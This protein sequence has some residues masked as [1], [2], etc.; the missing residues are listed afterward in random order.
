MQNNISISVIIPVYQDKEGLTDTV[1]SLIAQDFDKRQYEI[2]ISDNNSKDGTKQTATALHNGNPDLIRVVH[3]DTIQ[4]SYA[5]R[6]AAVKIARGEICCFID[7]DMTADSN[8]L[9]KVFNHFRNDEH[10]MYFGCNVLILK[11]ANTLS[12]SIN[13]DSGFKMEQYF[14]K[15]HFTPTASLSVRKSIFDT[16]GFF[17]E[18]LESGGDKEFGQRAYD[19]GLKQHYDHS[20]AL[21]HPS[22]ATY[23]AMLKKYKRIARGHAQLVHYYPER[24]GYYTSDRYYNI[25]HYFPRPIAK[26]LVMPFVILWAVC[27]YM[28]RL[29]IRLCALIEFNR[30]LRRLKKS[31]CRSPR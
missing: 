25:L 6:N 17:D 14:K 29:P 20:L 18:R 12:D 24:Y 3:Q 27:N 19:A 15:S 10:L 8:Y 4:S 5:T 22:R 21:F 1:N 30:E 13:R 26:F 23:S 9:L 7:A 11:T 2:I 28:Y 31:Q 16:V